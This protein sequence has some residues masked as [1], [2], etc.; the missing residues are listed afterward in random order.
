MKL[1]KSELEQ[2]RHIQDHLF[3]GCVLTPDQIRA[4]CQTLKRAPDL[5]E[6]VL[7]ADLPE[8][9]VAPYED[10]SLPQSVRFTVFPSPS[11]VMHGAVTMQAGTN[12]MRFLVSFAEENTVRLLDQAIVSSRI[13]VA[14]NVRETD[15]L[16]VTALPYVFNNVERLRSLV[17]VQPSVDDETKVAD[18]SFIV[19]EL[20]RPEA[21]GSSLRGVEVREVHVVGAYDWLTGCL[22]DTPDPRRSDLH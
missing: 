14:M 8:R 13:F 18:A 17:A 21:L 20:M 22:I 4:E 12:Q 9:C 19:R 2:L 10:A 5:N 16:A 7:Y 1:T 3:P 6:Y 11:G 15:Q